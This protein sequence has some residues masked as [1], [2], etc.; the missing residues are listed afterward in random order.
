[1]LN[2]FDK[3]KF[4]KRIK[5]LRISLG[6]S[7]DELCN[8]LDMNPSM[9]NTF[10]NGKTAPSLTTLIKIINALE[11]T[12]DI[13]FDCEHTMT[14]AELDKAIMEEYQALPLKKKQTLYRYI[15]ILKEYN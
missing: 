1:M 14:K 3:K 10:E 7:Q 13:I 11:T 4:G 9:L 8:R 5:Q 6:L 12:P 2:D 15:Q